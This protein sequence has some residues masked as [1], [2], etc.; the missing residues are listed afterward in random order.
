MQNLTGIQSCSDHAIT[1]PVQAAPSRRLN[2]IAIGGCHQFAH[3]LPVAFE[4]HRRGLVRTRIFVNTPAEQAAVADMAR[5]LE[6]QPPEIVVMS[7]PYAVERIL[8]K[9][10][11]KVAR[12]LAWASCLRDADAILTAER[13]STLLR[14]LPGKCPLLL[15]IPH[16]AGDRAVGFEKRFE[17]FDHVFVAGPK[18]RDR[19]VASG[20]VPADH[21]QVAG[22]IK[23]AAMAR[24][25]RGKPPLF[26]N[27]LPVLLYNPHFE[28]ELSSFEA[29]AQALIERV[30][31]DGRY[32][33]I[34]A[35]HVRLAR[36]WSAEKRARW[37]SLADNE[38]IIV[39]LGSVRSIDMTYTLAADLYIGDVSSQVY[40]FL[41][42]PRPCLFINAHNAAWQG[43]EDYAMWRFGE[44]ITPGSDLIAAIDNAFAQHAAYLPYQRERTRYA[45]GDICL[46]PE[47]EIS[48]NQSNPIATA[49]DMIQRVISSAAPATAPAT[50]AAPEGL[51]PA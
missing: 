9:A 42:R 21:C 12:L 24:Q 1:A 5:A 26:D 47:G 46:T 35:P 20:L 10:L 16:G 23:I 32:N 3:F 51:T 49:A 34:V 19:L 8:P 30:R 45:L 6:M 40:E 7:L 39:D 2:V 43:S 18:D 15:H 27:G 50:A 4:I 14:R 31:Q 41:V 29:T 48:I 22:P 25:H 28:A 37:E 17:L 11:H 33:L 13:T 38:R 36:N 44:V